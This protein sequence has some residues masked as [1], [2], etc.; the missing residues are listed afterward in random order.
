LHIVTSDG[1]GPYTGEWISELPDLLYWQ[2][3]FQRSLTQPALERLALE[4][5]QKSLNKFPV[6]LEKFRPL[7]R[8]QSAAGSRSY[9]S[10]WDWRSVLQ[11]WTKTMCVFFKLSLLIHFGS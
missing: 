11:T 5:K 7:D 3:F 10:R 8:F 4:Q 1:A 9:S 2:N 6:Y